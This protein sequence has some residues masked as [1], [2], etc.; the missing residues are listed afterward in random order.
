MED[1]TLQARS[2]APL[3]LPA[4]H[5]F[6]G[7]PKNKCVLVSPPP[8]LPV[9]SISHRDQRSPQKLLRFKLQ[10]GSPRWLES[11]GAALLPRGCS[12]CVG[13]SG[14]GRR[15][16]PAGYLRRPPRDLLGLPRPVASL[17]GAVPNERPPLSGRAPPGRLP[18]G[19]AAS[20]R[21]VLGRLASGRPP[22]GLPPPGLPP[23]CGARPLIAP[24][25]LSGRRSSR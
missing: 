12:R 9:F 10:I 13:G 11:R 16:L 18:V 4:K 17:R 3:S 24:P 7:P 23:R 5:L 14:G 20:E 1:P 2:T 6:F 8:R 22:L 25:R 21:G 19:R 15:G